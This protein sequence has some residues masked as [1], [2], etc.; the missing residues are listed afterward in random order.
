[1]RRSRLT[2]LL[3]AGLACA[4][5]ASS[6]GVGGVAPTPGAEAPAVATR[7][8]GGEKGKAI[9]LEPPAFARYRMQR[10]DTVALQ[11]P[12]GSVQNQTFGWS[13]WLDIRAS[14]ETNGHRLVITL[15][16]LDVEATN[17]PPQEAMDSA[18]GTRWTA[19]LDP[20]GHLSSVQADRESSIAEQFAAML[21]FLYPPLPGPSVRSGAMWT[22]SAT[23]PT[24]AQNF[25]VQE[26]DSTSYVVSGPSVHGERT[27]L[28]ISGTGSFTRTGSGDQFGQQMEYHSS[29]QRQATYYLGTDGI[30]AGVDGSESSKVTITVPAVGQSLTADQHSAFRVVLADSP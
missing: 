20:D 9:P 2:L 5:Q 11:L 25:E 16:S 29:G 14:A 19:H 4:P 27:A 24:R 12:N 22:D 15:D 3:M 23:V 28:V 18:R 26:Q 30:P 6:G 13:A 10:F 1:M 7:P 21:P 17:P 8:S